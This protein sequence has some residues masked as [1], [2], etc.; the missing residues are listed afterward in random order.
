MTTHD[1]N[2]TARIR[3]LLAL[4]ESP[5]E[6][7]ATAAAEKAQALLLKH[8]L[9]L[10]AV[11]ASADQE[12]GVDDT[13]VRDTGCTVPWR[14]SLAGAVARSLGGDITYL[15]GAHVH[16]YGPRGSTESM[17]ELYRYLERNLDRESKLAAATRDEFWVPTRTWRNS[18]LLGA[19][20]RLQERFKA[21]RTMVERETANPHAIVLVKDAV[22]RAIEDLHPNLRKGHYRASVD[23]A[24]AAAGDRAGARMGLGDSQVS[25]GRGALPAGSAVTS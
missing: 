12:I 5:N 13:Y 15:S 10:A 24:A 7:E 4:S 25:G 6:N 19:V 8:G 1:D 9:D 16:F 20:D 2:V 22:T 3:K 14:R 17:V 18:W 23:P 11:A 21:R